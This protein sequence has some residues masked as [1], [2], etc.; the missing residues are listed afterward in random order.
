MS[1][2]VKNE[3][4]NQEIMIPQKRLGAAKRPRSYQSLIEVVNSAATPVA[5]LTAI[6][7]ALV[8]S[9]DVS[10]IASSTGGR[11]L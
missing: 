7:P 11:I 10:D 3:G 5:S 2:G 8:Q 6:P 9:L 1:Y 4:L